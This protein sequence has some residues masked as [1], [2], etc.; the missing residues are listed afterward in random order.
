MVR[1]KTR[2]LLVRVEGNNNNWNENNNDT[3][4]LFPSKKELARAIRENLLQ[5][6]GIATI[7]SV[8]TQGT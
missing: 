5:C 2:W 3:Q 4:L 8:D 1:L 7:G 6:S